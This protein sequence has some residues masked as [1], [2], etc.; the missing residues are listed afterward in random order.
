MFEIR[1]QAAYCAH[2]LLENTRLAILA[3]KAYFNRI[4]RKV[5]AEA[6]VGGRF[7]A[8]GHL[9][10][11]I[12]NNRENN[13][14][15]LVRALDSV[16]IPAVKALFNRESWQARIRSGYGATGDYRTE[17]RHGF[18]YRPLPTFLA[19]KGLTLA[20]YALGAAVVQQ[21]MEKP[22]WDFEEDYR[23][24]DIRELP[25]IKRHWREISYL[26]WLKKMGYQIREGNDLT[27]VWGLKAK[28][29]PKQKPVVGG[30]I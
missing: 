19:E 5:V 2:A 1:P 22:D 11:G 25:V 12:Q 24:V 10:F 6:M 18:E 13:V 28:A 3:Q 21:A 30:V 9:H 29:K 17:H 14:P 7:P 16:L 26:V 4:Q 8:G 27:E 23:L 20:V 15:R